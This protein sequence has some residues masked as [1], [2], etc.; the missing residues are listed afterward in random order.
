[1]PIITKLVMPGI[2]ITNPIR[3]DVPTALCIFHPKEVSEGTISEPPPM[4]TNEDNRPTVPPITALN[5][6]LGRPFLNTMFFKR[7]INPKITHK[8][9]KRIFKEEL[10]NKRATI[11][12]PHAPINTYKAN[13][14]TTKKSTF[15]RAMCVF[16]DKKDVG[17]ITANDVPIAECIAVNTPV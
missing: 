15:P 2:A 9:P 17:I 3:A 1:M 11:A 8:E 12:P 10:S 4:P 13:F 7:N 14:R 6:I 16:A 5:K